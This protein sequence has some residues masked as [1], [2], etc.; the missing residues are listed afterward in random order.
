M[1][2]KIIFSNFSGKQ[3]ADLIF[4]NGGYYTVDGLDHQIAAAIGETSENCPIVYS[5]ESNIYVMN[6][7]NEI[8]VYSVDSQLVYQG[9]AEIIPVDHAGVYIV[10]VGDYVQKVMVK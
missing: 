3:T 8:R 2:E 7:E 6:A 9:R 4:K 1:P 10:T 5:A